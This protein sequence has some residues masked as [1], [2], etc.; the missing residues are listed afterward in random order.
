M[1]F[2]LSLDTLILLGIGVVIGF[3]IALIIYYVRRNTTFKLIA[4]AKEIE[5]KAIVEAETIKK[6]AALEGREKWFKQKA[7]MEDEIR[8]RQKELRIQEKKYNDRLS[9]LDKRLDSLDK[10]ESNLSEQ[11]RVIKNK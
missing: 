6:Q 7:S 5:E 2:R 8:E 4:N 10:K 9:T 1:N 3:A 11:E